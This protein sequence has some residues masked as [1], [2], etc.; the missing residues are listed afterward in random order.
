MRNII[1]H[2]N[3]SNANG[4]IYLKEEFACDPTVPVVKHISNALGMNFQDVIGEALVTKTAEGVETQIVLDSDT[5]TMIDNGSLFMF[6]AGTG[7]VEP[8]GYVRQ[9]KLH[10]IVIAPAFDPNIF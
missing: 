1:V 8:G 3:R 10:R 5:Q 9:Y 4:R 2:F 7:L 6:P